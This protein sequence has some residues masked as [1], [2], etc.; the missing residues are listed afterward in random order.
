MVRGSTGCEKLFSMFLQRG[1]GGG[2][3]LG[4]VGLDGVW[5]ASITSVRILG[6]SFKIRRGYINL[7][8]FP[9]RH[10]SYNYV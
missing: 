8:A 7:F 2:A 10:S 1:G 6:V 3:S 4:K 5:E 9:G